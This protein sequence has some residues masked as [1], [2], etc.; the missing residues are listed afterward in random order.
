M[1]KRSD[2]VHASLGESDRGALYTEAPEP[3]ECGD[4]YGDGEVDDD[5]EDVTVPGGLLLIDRC[6]SH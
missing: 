4:F 5:D 2:Q 6:M 3:C 1:S